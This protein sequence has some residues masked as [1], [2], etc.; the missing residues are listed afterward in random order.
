MAKGKKRASGEG[1]IRRRPSGLWEARYTTLEGKQKSLYA[2]T[3]SEVLRKLRQAIAERDGGVAFDA[4]NITFEQYLYRWLDDA[5]RDSVR[6]YTHDRY[7][8]IVRVHL[9][10]TLGSVRLAKLTP[11]HLQGLYRRK[12]EEGLSPST[13]GYV[14]TVANRALKQA[15]K[16]K[17]IPSN[18]AE[19][20]VPPKKKEEEVRAL[21]R[22]ETAALF[23]AVRGD[24]VEALYVVAALCGLRAGEALGLRWKDVDWEEGTL[25]VR[26][27]LVKPKSGYAFAP[28]K[29]KKGRRAVPLP[30]KALEA[31]RRHRARQLE[32][33][34]RVGKLWWESDLVFTTKTGALIDPTH[35]SRRLRTI[36]KRAGMPSE[37][38]SFH[39]LRHT[40]ATLM[41]LNG[42]HPKVVQETM[43][44]AKIAQTMDR[45]SHVLPNMQKDAA[46]RLNDLF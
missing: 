15:V 34:L 41:V 31:L 44:H 40:Y 28:P 37:G 16:W 9:A 46:K 30:E 1:H 14:H 35:L 3:Q 42:E 18:P 22:Q 25:R 12:L 2:K 26:Q 23:E 8:S 11:A 24:R 29:G 32:E 20:A 45:Y 39:G 17:L 5:V 38:F 4:E 13:V 36:L 27:Q 7:G 19:G 10:P 43:G 6:E 21:T 33:R